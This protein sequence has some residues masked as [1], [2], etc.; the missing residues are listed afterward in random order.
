MF[1]YY[2]GYWRFGFWLPEVFPLL[3]ISNDQN[4]LFLKRLCYLS[5]HILIN[6]CIGKHFLWK[7]IVYVYQRTTNCKYIFILYS[8]VLYYL[9]SIS[10]QFNSSLGSSLSTGYLLKTFS[11]GLFRFGHHLSHW[12][13]FF[14]LS[15]TKSEVEKWHKYT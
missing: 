12:R 4:A 5:I 6:Y 15:Y 11:L 9:I 3:R 14:Y 13:F 7:I 8:T 10:V 2:S 1:D